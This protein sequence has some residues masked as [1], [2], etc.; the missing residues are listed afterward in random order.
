MLFRSLSRPDPVEDVGRIG[1]LEGAY[2]YL[3][4]RAKEAGYRQ[5][6]A[7]LGVQEGL[8]AAASDPP[9]LVLLDYVLPDMKGDEVCQRL[10]ENAATASVPIV[11]MS[12]FGT[13]LPADE[14]KSPSVIGSLNKPFTSDLL[15]KT[16]ENYMP[17][18]PNEPAE[19]QNEIVEQEAEPVSSDEPA[20]RSEERRVGKECV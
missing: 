19:P 12:G 13:D 6:A 3:G 7:L 14:I 9:D 15:I 20:G 4:H 10:G 2:G 8:S 5:R 18:D 1:G 17:K 16:V 11:Y